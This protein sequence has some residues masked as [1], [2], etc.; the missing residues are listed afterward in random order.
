MNEW[1]LSS[2]M[3]AF[4]DLCTLDVAHLLSVCGLLSFHVFSEGLR[5]KKW[6]LKALPVS[7]W[8]VTYPV[9]GFTKMA[10]KIAEKLSIYLKTQFAFKKWF[11]L[12]SWVEWLGGS[13]GVDYLEEIEGLG[14]IQAGADNG[15][16]LRGDQ[17]IRENARV[18]GL[19]QTWQS[20]GQS[21]DFLS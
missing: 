21:P 3:V 9:L 1:P 14:Q 13:Q 6:S 2:H 19:P 20:W 4:C 8:M 5:L 12:Y 16:D 18:V 17:K 15:L 11:Q 7:L 10:K